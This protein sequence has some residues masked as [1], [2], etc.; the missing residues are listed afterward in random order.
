MNSERMQ[1]LYCSV[2]V[3]TTGD[4]TGTCGKSSCLTE[5]RLDV[6][7]RWWFDVRAWL[8]TQALNIIIITQVLFVLWRTWRLP[9]FISF[10]RCARI[11]HR[12]GSVCAVCAVCAPC[13][14]SMRHAC[15][16][17]CLQR[18]ICWTKIIPQ[19]AQELWFPKECRKG[20]CN[21]GSTWCKF[22]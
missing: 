22:M 3:C 8:T 19:R 1:I 16:V 10:P 7:C 11:V 20:S 21:M 18:T 13:V 14:W 5:S 12:K 4:H 9:Q 15:G 6:A 17:S 2:C